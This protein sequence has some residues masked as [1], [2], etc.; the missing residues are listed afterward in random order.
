MSYL[1][2]LS[3]QIQGGFHTQQ[4]LQFLG[5]QLLFC[6]AVQLLGVNLVPGKARGKIE[7]ALLSKTLQV[8]ENWIEESILIIL[9]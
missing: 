2:R 5:I 3:D 1:R 6:I 7:I 8:T 9:R 4:Y